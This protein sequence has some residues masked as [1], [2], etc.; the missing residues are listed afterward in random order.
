P[1]QGEVLNGT[2]NLVNSADE[3][4]ANQEATSD[5]TDPDTSTML[6]TITQEKPPEFI[7]PNTLQGTYFTLTQARMYIG[8]MFIDE[9]NGCQFALQD[10]KIPIYGYASRFYDSI[11]QGKSLVQG[12]LTINFVSEGYLYTVLQEYI[13]TVATDVDSTNQQA[14]QNANRLL[15]LTNALQNPDPSWTPTMIANAKKEIQNL[16]ASLGSSAVDAASAGINAQLRNQLD[17]VLGLAGGDYPNAVYQ[18]IPFDIVLQFTGAGRTIIRRLEDVHLISNESILDP[19]G[20]P[21]LD[22]YGF[23]CRRLR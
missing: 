3:G 21:I 23:I 13:N 10:N 22:S 14:Q 15:T 20:T 1:T 8:T 16:A 11:A 12:Q 4:T 18:G 17:N 2:V 6:P 7:A 19:S 9:L 5:Q